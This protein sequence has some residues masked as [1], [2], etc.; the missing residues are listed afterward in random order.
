MKTQSF[1]PSEVERRWYLVDAQGKVLGR[2][3]TKIA[4]LLR[5][6]GKPTFTP[7]MD[8]GDF[9]VVV[10]AEK[11]VVTGKK[12]DQKIYYK[13]SGYPG[14]LHG[15]TFADLQ[16]HKPDQIVRMAVKGMLPHNRLGRQMFKKLRVYAGPD[17]PHVGQSPQPIDLD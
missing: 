8:N 11:V 1:K 16:E 17:H 2:L 5:G 7:H 14:G 9:V 15:Q 10:N 13:H 12:R 4:S 6:K 3:A